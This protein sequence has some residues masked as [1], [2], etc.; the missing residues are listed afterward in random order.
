MDL[1]DAV[2]ALQR[3]SL[4]AGKRI[5]IVGVSTIVH[6]GARTYFEVGKPKYWLRRDDGGTTVGVGGI[7][8]TIEQGES[9]VACLRREVEEELGSRVR[10]EPPPRKRA[11]ATGPVGRARGRSPTKRAFPHPALR[12]FRPAP[13]STPESVIPE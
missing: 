11:P 6:D 4:V 1:F 3:H 2:P 12:S 9:V 13:A 5:P 7:G 8:G 10:L